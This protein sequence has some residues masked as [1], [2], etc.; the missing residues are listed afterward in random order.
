MPA[1]Q[2]KLFPERQGGDIYLSQGLRV[3]EDL[4]KVYIAV[5]SHFHLKAAA[6]GKGIAI[7]IGM[8]DACQG[9]CASYLFEDHFRPERI[10]GIPGYILRQVKT[11]NM[12]VISGIFHAV[13]TLNGSAGFCHQLLHFRMAGNGVVIR[14]GKGVRTVFCHMIQQILTA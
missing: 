8:G 9:P 2:H 10:N 14:E 1:L 3:I 12:S 13:N 4:N 6:R 11:E 7:G 5:I